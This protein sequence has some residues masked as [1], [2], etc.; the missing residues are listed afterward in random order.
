MRA[1]SSLQDG[2]SPNKH[3]QEKYTPNNEI[4]G[5]QYLTYLLDKAVLAENSP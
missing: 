3:Q 5:T 1:K 4:F 2:N